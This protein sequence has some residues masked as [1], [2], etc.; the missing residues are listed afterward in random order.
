MRG[1]VDE[2]RFNF[3][4]A[5]YMY[6]ITKMCRFVDVKLDESTNGAFTTKEVTFPNGIYNDIHEL[7]NAINITCKVA[8]SHFYFEQQKGGKVLIRINYDEK[9]KML[10]HINFSDNLLRMLGFAS[11]ISRNNYPFYVN[12]DI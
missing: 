3:L 7:I 11:A 1:L 10:H 8:E 5:F 2:A 6:I 4:V 12:H 9:C